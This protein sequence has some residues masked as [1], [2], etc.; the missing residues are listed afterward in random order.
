AVLGAG[1]WGTAL[2]IAFGQ[3]HA[4]SLWTRDPAQARLLARTRRNAR[5]LPGFELPAEIDIEADLAT[6]LEGCAAAVCAVPMSGLRELVESIR[7]RHLPLVLA[8]KGFEPAS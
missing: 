1:A 6:A 2:T 5:Y 3:Q 7:G 4:V 8:C